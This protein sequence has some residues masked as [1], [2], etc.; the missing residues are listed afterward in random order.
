MV[1][2]GFWGGLGVISPLPCVD[3]GVFPSCDTSPRVPAPSP[4]D[5]TKEERLSEAVTVLGM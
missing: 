3:V 1:V 5:D 2:L 4:H